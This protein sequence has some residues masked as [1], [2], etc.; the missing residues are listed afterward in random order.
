MLSNSIIDIKKNSNN[1]N[2]N[3]SPVKIIMKIEKLKKSLKLQ[4]TSNI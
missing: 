4:K 2:D 1:K 3:N